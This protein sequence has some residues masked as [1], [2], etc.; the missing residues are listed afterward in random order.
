[1]CT[2]SPDSVEGICIVGQFD[3]NGN[4]GTPVTGTRVDGFTVDGFS[5]FGLLAFNAADTTVS[6][7]EARDNKSYGISGFILSGVSYLRNT[8][9]DNGE[10]GFYIGDS[11]QAN[12]VV[13]GNTSFR[14]GVGG[15]EGFGFLFRDSSHGD[16]HGNRASGNCAGFVFID[17]GENPDPMAHWTAEN[18]YATANNGSCP[19]GGGPPPFSG[20]G[21]ILGGTDDVTLRANVVAGN[22]PSGPSI[23]SA[24]IAVVSTVQGGGAKPSNNVVAHNIVRNNQ[25]FDIFWDKSGP[26]NRFRQNDCQT[27]QPSSICSP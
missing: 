7:M 12:A 27:S 18:N 1:M 13:V 8:A 21:I 3:P 19:G 6:R 22:V 4:P 9:H 23:A 17:T 5:D 15:A 2:S 10:P 20:I 24:G 11:P 16:V 14:N 25:P 26:N